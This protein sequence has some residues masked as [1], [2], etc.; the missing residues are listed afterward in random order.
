M[1]DCCIV[2]GLEIDRDKILF[3]EIK[4]DS[5]AQNMVLLFA[6]LY[7]RDT[8]FV[9]EKPISK[10]RMMLIYLTHCV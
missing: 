1:E 9:N 3:D 5:S 8:I 4:V 6:K 2:V 7:S 10:K